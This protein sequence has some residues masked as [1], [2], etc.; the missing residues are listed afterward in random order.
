M[1]PILRSFSKEA[2]AD[3]NR[4]YSVNVNERNWEQ[5]SQLIIQ[6][7]KRK[8]YPKLIIDKIDSIINN[9]YNLLDGKNYRWFVE[10][11]NLNSL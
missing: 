10:L 4:E 11:L 8:R 7:N 1:Y 2:I 3:I 5:V 9:D 6:K